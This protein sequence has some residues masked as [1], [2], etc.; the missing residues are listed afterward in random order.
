VGKRFFSPRAS[1]VMDI[2]MIRIDDRLIHGQ[3]VV[4]WVSALRIQR[5]VVVNDS[6][7][8]NVMQRTLMEIAVPTALKV[9]F[10]TVKEAA[11]ECL[12]PG[13]ERALLLFTKP[14]DI[15]TFLEDGGPVTAINMGG[16]HYSDGRRQAGPVLF[17]NDEDVLAFRDLK[18]KG[19]PIEV[20]AVPGDPGVPLEQQLPEIVSK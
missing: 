14:L 2:Q 13:G 16:M 20:R 9:S 6:V 10:F 19:I 18:R 8:A 7:A 12:V 4:G 1:K 11:R 5:L 3:V 17:V 15:W